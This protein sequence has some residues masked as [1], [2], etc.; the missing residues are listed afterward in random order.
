MEEG[1]DPMSLLDSIKCECVKLVRGITGD[2][3]GGTVQTYTP[4]ERF[5]AYIGFLSSAANASADTVREQT[6]VTILTSR[7][8][9]LNLHDLIRRETDG[10]VFRITGDADENKTPPIADLDLRAVSAEEW[11]VPT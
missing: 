6:T 10:K 7:K 9:V 5:T 4:G 11:R 8:T 2:G 1:E 3:D